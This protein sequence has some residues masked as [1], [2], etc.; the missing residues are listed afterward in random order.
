MSAST[1][2]NYVWR[3]RILFGGLLIAYGV[4]A[5]LNTLGAFHIDSIQ[6]YWP[7]ILIALGVNSICEYPSAKHVRRGVWYVSLGVW[8]FVSLQQIGGLTF[9]NSWPMLLVVLGAGLVAAGILRSRSDTVN[10][11]ST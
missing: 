3:R 2:S 7:L 6:H 11:P 4:L 1:S 8:L 9:S 5:I 10:N